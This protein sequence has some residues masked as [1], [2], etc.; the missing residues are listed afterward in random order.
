MWT[1]SHNLDTI[2]FV[3]IRV[4]IHKHTESVSCDILSFT[5][6]TLVFGLCGSISSGTQKEFKVTFSLKEN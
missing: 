1:C 6:E 4:I 5:A 2:L 3:D